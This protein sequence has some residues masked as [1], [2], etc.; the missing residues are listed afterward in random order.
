MAKKIQKEFI[1]P[2]C[3]K[4]H[5][6]KDVVY[7]CT[8][9][10]AYVNCK[11]ALEKKKIILNKLVDTAKCD[12]CKENMRMFC[13]NKECGYE[14]PSNMKYSANYPIALIG[15][16]EVGKTNY[17]AVL[18]EQI[19]NN[20]S[21]P[22]D[23]S[24]EAEPETVKRFANDFR[25]PL[26]KHRKCLLGTDAGEATP[27]IYTL[28][29]PG[30]KS[31]LKKSKKDSMVLTFYD[32]AG[33]NLDEKAMLE[34]HNRYLSYSSAILLL[35]DPLQIQAVREQLVGKVPLPDV[36]TD[37]N[38][39]LDRIITIIRDARGIPEDVLDIDIA[40]AFTKIDAVDSLLEPSS[41]LKNDSTHI[42]KGGFDKNDFEDE[43]G[44]M[45]SL[46]CSWLGQE[47][48]QKL[49]SNFKNYAFFGVS[50]LGSSPDLENNVPKFRPFRVTD[51]FL[52]ILY[53]N[54]K[55]NQV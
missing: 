13:P 32:T 22:F 31:L 14:I 41:C 39:L 1:C 8:N 30:K 19:K 28:K 6:F 36:R 26:Y 43:N 46:V 7:M 21:M 2:K 45:Q 42:R 15:A 24:L 51:P 52:W 54:G 53:Q 37:V 4:K 55:I 5:Q 33:E 34:S 44:E 3:F 23:L 10:N 40:V 11:N 27:L 20:L 25:D 16:K 18:I 48:I 47:L 50:A 29:L 9:T 49:G 38:D 35:L 17:I 12:C